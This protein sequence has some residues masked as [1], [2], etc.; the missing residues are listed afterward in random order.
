M[1][2]GTSEAER[3][4]IMTVPI[5]P[6]MTRSYGMRG[7]AESAGRERLWLEELFV[8]IELAV[9]AGEEKRNVSISVF[10]EIVHFTSVEGLGIDVNADGALVEFGEVH[11]FVDG[12]HGIDVGGMSGV[13]IV[14]FGGNDMTGTFSG[15][16]VVH[17]I[18]LYTQAAD[19]R[20]HPAILSAMIVNAAVL[21]DVPAKRHALEENVAEDEIARVISLG[22]KAIFFEAFRAHG[23]ADDI[24]LDVLQRELG[25]ADGSEAFD[26][27]FDGEFFGCDRLRHTVPPNPGLGFAGIAKEL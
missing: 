10:I 19:G 5:R 2:C 18:I 11:D 17:T 16:A 13:E 25:F 24:V 20:G 1:N 14:K 6:I 26:P 12:L 21:P 22:E 27:V 8:R 23:V 15:V 3:K 7:C 4:K 9:F